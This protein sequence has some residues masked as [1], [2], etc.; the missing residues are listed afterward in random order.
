[1][2]LALAGLGDAAAARRDEG[3]GSVILYPLG[4]LFFEAGP[5]TV[6]LEF[7]VS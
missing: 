4:I 7:R 2:G 5:H 3:L 6:E 1:L